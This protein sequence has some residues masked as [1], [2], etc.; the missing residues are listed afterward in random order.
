[1]KYLLHFFA[2]LFSVSVFAQENDDPVRI[3]I[4]SRAEVFEM[5][6]CNERGVLVFYESIKEIDEQTKA[7]VFIFYDNMLNPVWSKELPVY[8]DFRYAGHYR[9]GEELYL[10][11]H[12]TEKARREEFNFQL[13]RINLSDTKYKAHGL[14]VPD[15]ATLVNFEINNGILAAGFNFG[16]DEAVLIVRDL[17]SGEE[18]VVQYT[19]DPTFFKDIRIDQ[20]SGDIYAAITLYSSRKESALYLNSYTRQATLKNSIMIATPRPTQKLMNAQLNF[21]PGNEI[22]VLGSF[23]NFNGSFSRSDE[24]EAGEESEGF[25]IAKINAGSQEFI[26]FHKLLDFKNITE[27]LNNEELA[28]VQNLIEKNKKGREQTLYYEFLIHDLKTQ[29]D[30][31]IMLAEAY[32]PEYHQ[33]STMSYD[34]YGRPMPYYYTVFDGYRYFN[35]FAVSFDRDGNLNWSNGIKIWNMLSKRLLKKVECHV[36]NGEVVLFYNYD[37]KV[38]SK[39][40]DGYEQLGTIENTRLSTMHTNDVQIEADRGMISHWYKDYFLASGY[41]TLRNSTLGGGSKRRVFYI[42]KLIFN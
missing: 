11:F 20:K 38:I 3:E 6:P 32:Y 4:E 10:S 30:N 12:K 41:Q 42:N 29:G 24:T 27:I 9:D 23:N 7:W 36:D 21:V 26:K 8:R 16:K 2:L 40:I 37:G 28:N 19:D 35:A 39:V 33:V 18:S 15:R 14:F 31:F 5:V 34:F 25:Y 22:F 1:M 17:D 13:M